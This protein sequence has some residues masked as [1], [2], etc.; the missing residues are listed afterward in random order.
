MKD[1]QTA[2]QITPDCLVQD[3]VLRHPQAITVFARYG[4]P[5][6]G[7][8][9]APYHTIADSARECAA[10]LSPLLDDLNR[11]IAVA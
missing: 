5:C 8:Y 9:I 1:T 7:C 4:M 2:E 10:P 6:V 3:I 11:T